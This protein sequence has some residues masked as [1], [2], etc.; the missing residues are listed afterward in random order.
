M[1][2]RLNLSLILLFLLGQN[3]F[4]VMERGDYPWDT[5]L[6]SFYDQEMT[7]KF[8]EIPWLLNLGPTGIRARIYKDKPKHLV[9]KYVFQDAK[10]PAKGK[11]QI[12]DVIVG[13]NGK[14]F[15]I[16]FI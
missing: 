14:K 5:K 9:V 12:E 11:V 15:K 4:A 2:T 6:R 13:A 3:A 16:I 1:K 7:S 8:A 10:S